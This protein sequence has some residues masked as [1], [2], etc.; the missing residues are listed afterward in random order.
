MNR[1]PIRTVSVK[2][3]KENRLRRKLLE[4]KFG[5]RPWKCD[6]EGN[7]IALA[8]GPCQGEVNAHELLKRSQGGS[9]L[10]MDNVIPLC[11]Y[12]NGWVEDNPE[13]AHDFGYVIH[14]WEGRCYQ[15]G[16]S[17]TLTLGRVNGEQLCGGC[18][19]ELRED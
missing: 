19:S 7:L 10:D 18:T 12:H 15:C 14:P 13:R 17:I 16:D 8:M 3:D 1:T 6:V 2:R 11:N 4:E 5:P 9:I